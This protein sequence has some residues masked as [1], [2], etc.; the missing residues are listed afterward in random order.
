MAFHVRRI[1]TGHD[2]SGKAVVIMDGDAPGRREF[3]KEAGGR[4]TVKVWQ[5]EKTPAEF[6]DAD[7]GLVPSGVAPV[8]T[9]SIFR[10]VEYP[11]L[12]K[13]QLEALSHATVFGD[14]HVTPGAGAQANPFMHRTE[15]VDYA[16]CL[17]GEIDMLLDDS[18]V[19]MKAGDVM[20]QQGTNH[21]WVNT[22]TG[23]CVMAFV[24]IGAKR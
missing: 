4:T 17:S 2:K 5:T 22:G 8:P 20:V 1:V 9:G 6:S 10:I 19:H 21:G 14:D 15:S 18:T 24:L 13:A 3:P 23:P 11:A 16:I 12:T 7:T